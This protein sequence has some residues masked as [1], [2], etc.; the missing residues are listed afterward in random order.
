MEYLSLGTPGLSEVRE[1]V[2]CMSVRVLKS[3]C[4]HVCLYVN[5]Q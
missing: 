3:V 1:G 2:V 5:M 4:L